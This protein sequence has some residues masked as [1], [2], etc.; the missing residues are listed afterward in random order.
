[1]CVDFRRPEGIASTIRQSPIITIPMNSNAN[2]STTILPNM[3]IE[4]GERVDRLLIHGTG[5]AARVRMVDGGLRSSVN[6]N[7]GWVE[8]SETHHVSE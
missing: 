1:M 3:R 8:R 5:G 6:G 2:A 4:L 7:V